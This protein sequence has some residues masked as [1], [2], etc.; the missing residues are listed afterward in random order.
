MK[1]VY[2][3]S[4]AKRIL[5][6]K[7]VV[8]VEIWGNCIW[9]RFTKGSRFVSKK[10]FWADFMQNRKLKAKQLEVRHY[11]EELWQVSSQSR[12]EPYIVSSH[13]EIQCECEDYANQV[14]HKLPYPIC[15]HGWAVVFKLGF[16]SF[17]EYVKEKGYLKCKAL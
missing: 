8:L 7:D 17:K 4:A 2:S 11:G 6:R 13:E 15:K 10:D 12:F 9:V 14:K 1:L 16:G 3:E 5:G